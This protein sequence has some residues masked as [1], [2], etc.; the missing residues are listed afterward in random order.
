MA[1]ATNVHKSEEL[2]QARMKSSAALIR[3]EAL[4]PGMKRKKRGWQALTL[5]GRLP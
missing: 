2:N 5:T 1:H 4:S 3:I